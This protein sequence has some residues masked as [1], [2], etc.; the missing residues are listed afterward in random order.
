MNL[1]IGGQ[2]KS[3]LVISKRK[4][5][6]KLRLPSVR[7]PQAFLGE[8]LSELQHLT[9][10]LGFRLR[11]RCVCLL[12]EVHHDVWAA[13]LV[14]RLVSSLE[15]VCRP[16]AGIVYRSAKTLP[17]EADKDIAVLDA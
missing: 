5:G 15:F 3:G 4:S 14:P 7:P 8:I 11:L 6:L 2:Y 12:I 16:G 13:A 1:R 10:L 17:E 9:P